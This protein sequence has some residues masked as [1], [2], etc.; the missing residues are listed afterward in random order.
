M[1]LGDAA[2]REFYEQLAER[3]SLTVAGLDS[4]IRGD[5]FA[6]REELAA[7]AKKRRRAVTRP[8]HSF[9]VFKAKVERVID[10]DT[11]V[12]ML[13]TGFNVHSKER[14]RFAQVNTARRNSAAGKEATG[15]VLGKLARVPFIVVQTINR[16]AHGRY[17]G[18]IFYM[19][20]EPR[21]QTVFEQG[22]HLNA[23]LAERGLG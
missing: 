18:H 17:V 5:V 1:S 15:Y 12:A 16:D 4:A 7:E 20:D 21:W 8:S 19:P 23:E 10:G 11:I 6:Q 3:E 22:R 2:E 13:D 14:I 9:Y